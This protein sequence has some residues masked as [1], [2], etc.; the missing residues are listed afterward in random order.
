MFT[1]VNPSHNLDALLIGTAEFSFAEDAT[2]V[3]EAKTIGFRD[4]GN[5]KAFTPN[6]DN[7][8][9][10]HKGSYRGVRRTDKSVVTETNF[11]YVLKCDEWNLQLLKILFGGDDATGWTQAALTEAAAD[12]LNFSSTSSDTT[13]WYDLYSSGARLRWMDAVL[14]FA[15]GSG[16]SCV[17]DATANTLTAVSHGLSDGDRVAIGGSVVPGGLSSTVAY[18]VVNAASDT[19][20]VSLTSGGSA[21][22]ITSTGTSVTFS[23]ALVE[24]TNYEADL[25]LGRVRFLTTVSA[26]LTPFVTVPVVGSTDEKRFKGIT[27]MTNM[28]RR[29]IGRLVVYDQYDENQV[30]FDH[31]D[32]SCEIQLDS[33]GEVNGSDFSEISIKVTITDLPGTVLNRYKGSLLS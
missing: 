25:E 19:F 20:K 18:Y 33:S 12:T 6:T 23:E 14:F 9:Q 24:G 22:D 17:A 8:K 2:T 1:Q 27:P 15:I 10:E 11:N 29:G 16:V 13:K 3:A 26:V 4:F 30:V 31:V 32:F 28:T 7:Q 5:I 21:V